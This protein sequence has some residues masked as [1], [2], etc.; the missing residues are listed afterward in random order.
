MLLLLF[1][2]TEEHRACYTDTSA[3][4]LPESQGCVKVHDNFWTSHLTSYVIITSQYDYAYQRST[5]V[6]S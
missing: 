6:F 3:D 5:A 4:R 2:M 1:R